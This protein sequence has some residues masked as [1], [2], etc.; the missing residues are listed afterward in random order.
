[1]R[2][3][4]VVLCLVSG[5]AFVADTASARARIGRIVSLKPVAVKATPKPEAARAAERP[6]VS[7]TWI[8]ATPRSASQAT[9]MP[10]A[11]GDMRADEPASSFAAPPAAPAVA[12]D[13]AREEPAASPPANPAPAPPPASPAST[14]Q[15][16]LRVSALNAALAPRPLR[17][18]PAQPYEFAI[19]Y[20]NRA[21]Q[22]IP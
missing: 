1:M 9:G 10:A 13:A 18:A 15:Q 11:V 3:F 7:R 8:V 19:C 17:A 6:A 20:W 4:W 14:P 21:G 12:A 22:C 16:P 5:F 2:K